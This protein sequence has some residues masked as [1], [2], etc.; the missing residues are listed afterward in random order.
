MYCMMQP[1]RAIGAGVQSALMCMRRS[2][3]ACMR[4]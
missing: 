3:C 2:Y 4:I 1:A